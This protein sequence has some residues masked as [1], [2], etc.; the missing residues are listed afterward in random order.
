M[1]EEVYFPAGAGIELQHLYR[2][3]DFV[4]E[5]KGRIEEELYWR[6]GDLLSMDVDLI[7]YDTTSVYFEVDG[8]DEQEEGLRRRGYSKDG[9]GDAP[10]VV[11][12]MAVTRDGYPVKSWVFPGNRTDVSTLQEV[13]E[14]L[15]GWRLNRCIFVTDAGMVSEDNL[16]LLRRG[17]GRYIVA[18]PCRRGTEVVTEV[19]SRAG[20]Y[21]EVRDNLKV[22][23]VRVGE[24]RYVV[25]YNPEEAERQ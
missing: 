4:A 13:K 3:M 15:R 11:V 20:R 25:C 8:E 9:R 16:G 12:G 24:R 2:A 7:F 5:H 1:A 14:Q 17:G 19:L 18:M 6:L 23:E 21:E 10:Q 22:K